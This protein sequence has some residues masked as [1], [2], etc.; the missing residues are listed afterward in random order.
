MP[1]PLC[2]LMI[3]GLSL[4]MSLQ[5]QAK[6]EGELAEGM[7]NPG[8]HA[9]PGWFKNSFLDVLE[10]IAEA[11]EAGGQTRKNP[12]PVC[13]RM[14]GNGV[15]RRPVVSSREASVLRPRTSPAPSTAASIAWSA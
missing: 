3:C 2:E 10:D 5:V 13:I 6:R 9:Q 7:V 15:T 4:L 12:N 11:R 1:H 14:W 8:Y